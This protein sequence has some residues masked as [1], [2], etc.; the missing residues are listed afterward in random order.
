MASKRFITCINLEK[1][2]IQNVSLEKLAADPTGFEGRIIYNTT[3]KVL[4]YYD[5]TTWQTASGDLASTLVAGNIT[6]G[7]DI[8]MT[9]GDVITAPAGTSGGVLNMN[10][11]GN[12]E[13]IL[14][15]NTTGGNGEGI[16]IDKAGNEYIALFANNYNDYL[17][18][19]GS[20][21]EA[22]FKAGSNILIESYTATTGAVE[23]KT[24]NLRF[25]NKSNAFYFHIDGTPTAN[26]TITIQ[27][28]TGT[29]A[30]LTDIPVG[31]GKK[32]ETY[33]AVRN[34]SGINLSQDLRTGEGIPTNLT[35]FIIPY[36]G[37]MHGVSVS[38][39]TGVLGDSVDYQVLV[40]DVVQHTVTLTGITTSTINTGLAV[41][42]TA[43]DRIRLRVNVN[44]GPIVNP[45]MSTYFIES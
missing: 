17:E 26:R 9:T 8:E 45:V 2:E 40:N 22:N 12:G 39:E 23:L 5:G 28:G 32:Q 18:F 41:A 4:K 19:V 42:V 34:N 44:S 27:D 1:Q 14:L 29:L 38:R 21:S 31:S 37:T 35:P 10:D 24:D 15:A 43:G 36:T 20:S 11:A 7:T 33:T 25:S 6:G 16:W 3:G 13:I 30:F